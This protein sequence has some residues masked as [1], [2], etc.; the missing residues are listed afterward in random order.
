MNMPK[1]LYLIPARGGSKGIPGKN[2]RPLC[3]IPLIGHTI[4][5][6]LEVA[7]PE[8]VVVTTDDEAI[9]G[10][11]RA[12]GASV[13]FMRPARLASD[14]ASSRDAILHAIDWMECHGRHYDAVV[15][16]QPTSP[17]RRADDIRRC[18]DAFEKALRAGDAPDMAVTVCE[19][20]TNPYC[21]AFETDTDGFLH[22]SKGDGHYTRRQDAPKVWEFN[23]A[24]YVID[25][26]ALRREEISRL[27][28][29]LPVDMPADRSID[30][31]T[32][33]DWDRAEVA[34]RRLD[35]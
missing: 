6:A 23:G 24:V 11:A 31:D 16:L 26:A 7:P 1:Y 2:I 12:H 21:S 20:R 9:A 25:V 4:S 10:T 5:Q 33:A 35:M 18:V 22:I 8:D 34:M 13:P 3:G 27:R 29:T 15:L 32:L 19:A 30:L 28:R 17:L 14:T